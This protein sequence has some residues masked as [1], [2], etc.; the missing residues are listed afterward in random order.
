[1]A[2]LK[3]YIHQLTFAQYT[4]TNYIRKQLKFKTMNKLVVLIGIV[5]FSLQLNAQT[6]SSGI[7]EIFY[8]RCTS[9]HRTGGIG[10]FNIIS[11]QDVVNNTGGIY[12]AII[13]DRM[14]PWPPDNTYSQ[15]LHSRAL[16]PNEKSTLLDW[17]N[18]G[19]PEGNAAETPPPPVFPEGSILGDGDL[20]LQIPAYTSQA[21]AQQ[22]DYVCISI[23]TGLTQSKKIRAIE[24]IP[25]NAAIVHHCL[26]YID[27]TGNYQTNL[28]GSCTGPVGNQYKLASGYVPGSMPMVFPNNAALRMGLTVP[29]GSNLVF[30]MHYPSGSGG[31]ADSTRVI[32][33]FYPDGTPGVREV[34]A[35]PVLQNWS[36]SLPANQITT[37]NAT[38]SIPLDISVFSIFP[39]MHLIGK[40]IKAYGLHQGDTIKLINIPKWDFHWQGF[41]VFQNLQ[42]LPS[43]TSLRGQGI[44]DNTSTNVH[45][46]NN[47][48]ITIGPG[49]NTSDEM[50]IYYGH[51]MPY[52]AG[53]ENHD[54]GAMVALNLEAFVSDDNPQIKVYP[55]PFSHS[56]T[57]DL[58]SIN[59]SQQATIA[60]YDTQGKLIK[61]L[62]NLTP[63]DNS[64]I[65][66]N[67]TDA[68][69][70]MTQNGVYYVSILVD[71]K[72]WLTKA[73][74]KV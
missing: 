11:Y 43:G 34:I 23:P 52:Q 68:Q 40:S 73:V 16:S 49:L 4:K 63:G 22:D 62:P 55:N 12:D 39:H 58:S 8:N 14:P 65:V 69:N 66:W 18:N 32:L 44:Y 5:A 20:E 61:R 72:V 10:P 42:K 29:A 48:P 31:Q 74:V 41:Y 37:V 47:P 7:A 53:D 15:L 28:N 36:F 54:L 30:A 56:L 9:C 57:L 25:G 50:F 21:T 38:Q 27:E 64:N 3:K 67:G 26:L 19:M 6:F 71:G 70:Q 24:I 17:M 2:K 51:Y 13:Q 33:H 60:I 35:D 59:M 1:M 46:P 45:N